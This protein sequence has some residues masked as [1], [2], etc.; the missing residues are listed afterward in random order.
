MELVRVRKCPP[1]KPASPQTYIVLNSTPRFAMRLFLLVSSPALPKTCPAMLMCVLFLNTDN[2]FGFATHSL[3]H[4]TSRYL[5]RFPPIS[6]SH[7]LN[8]WCLVHLLGTCNFSHQLYDQALCHIL[9]L[10]VIFL[11]WYSISFV[12]LFLVPMKHW[13]PAECWI[14]NKLCHLRLCVCSASDA[15]LNPRILFNF[16]NFLLLYYYF[17]AGNQSEN[18]HPFDTCYTFSLTVHTAS[19]FFNLHCIVSKMAPI[20]ALLAGFMLTWDKLQ[21]LER[22]L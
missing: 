1:K 22:S 2:D 4:S 5:N 18:S 17:S 13:V 11:V 19:S 16:S 7:F 21:S 8:K 3:E 14:Q 15:S 10:F 6:L 9:K 12:S 20:S